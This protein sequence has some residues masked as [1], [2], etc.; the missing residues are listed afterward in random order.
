MKFVVAVT[1]NFLS[2]S[3]AAM[4]ANTAIAADTTIA[5]NT[6]I[7]TAAMQL[8]HLKQLK[9]PMQVKCVLQSNPQPKDQTISKFVTASN[10]VKGTIVTASIP[11]IAPD[12]AVFP[13]FATKSI[14]R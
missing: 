13:Q 11:G 6:T 2:P 1:R 10:N 3:I 12:D 9:Q 5:A 4:A 8:R 7:A 14:P